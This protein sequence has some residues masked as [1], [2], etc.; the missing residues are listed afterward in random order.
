[1]YWKKGGKRPAHRVCLFTMIAVFTASALACGGCGGGNQ[2]RVV[3]MGFVQADIHDL[4]YYVAREKRFFQDE[5][6]DVREGGAFNSGAELMSSFSAGELDM[7]YVGVAP[8]LTFEARDMADIKIVAAINT[9]GSALV[10]RSGL[11]GE[12]PAAL[13]GRTVAVS[14][15]STVQDMLLGMALRKAGL[16]RTDVSAV[17]LR[18]Q[19]MV[20]ALRG[21]RIDGFLASEPYPSQAV[22]EKAGRVLLTSEGIWPGHP[23]CVLVADAAFVRRSPDTVRRVVAAHVR[24]TDYVK[25]N[26]L[27]AKDMARLFTG[28][29]K[30]IVDGAMK[31]MDFTYRLDEKKLG[32][33]VLFM[34]EQGVVEKGQAGRL[35]LDIVDKQ[36]LPEKGT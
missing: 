1:M 25:D 33:Y 14:G 8:A 15:F 28:L 18:P 34:E 31:N 12:D 3:R 26:P 10:A 36:F 20:D 13:K 21:S 30:E 24:A 5:G 9:G 19:D 35:T 27:E 2:S 11:E 29:E 16:T 4:A 7:G 23:C 32:R 6:L 17:S 22:Q